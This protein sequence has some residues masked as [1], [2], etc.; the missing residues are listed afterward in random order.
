MCAKLDSRIFGYAGPKGIVYTRYAD[1]I[2]LSAQTAQKIYKAKDFIGTIIS[3][4]GLKINKS[5]TKI[6]GT[7]RQKKITGLILSEKNVGIGQKKFKDIR[8]KIHYLFIEKNSNYSN[9]NGLLA[10]TYSV[11][12]KAYKR[13]YTYIN[14]LMAKFP[15]HPTISELHPQITN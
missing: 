6:C 5:K 13:L 3:N 7:T 12:K 1:D 14:K 8:I 15:H 2:T 9:V 11:D 4:E 10:F